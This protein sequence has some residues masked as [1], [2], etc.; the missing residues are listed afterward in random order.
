VMHYADY[1]LALKKR[2]LFF[3]KVKDLTHS[4][5]L[6]VIYGEEV[7]FDLLEDEQCKGR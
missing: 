5:L 7:A 6:S 2:V 4:Q 1:V 3:G